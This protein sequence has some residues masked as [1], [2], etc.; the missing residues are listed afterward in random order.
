VRLPD[1]PPPPGPFRAEFWRSPL[2]RA[3]SLARA[4]LR[5]HRLP[6][7]RDLDEPDDARALAADRRVPPAVVERLGADPAGGRLTTSTARR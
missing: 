1:P 2:R 7:E 4:R 5:V 6:V 3:A